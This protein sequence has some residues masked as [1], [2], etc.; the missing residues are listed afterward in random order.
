M[1]AKLYINL[2]N[3][4]YNI[5]KIREKLKENTGII[6]MVKANAYGAGMV[7]VAK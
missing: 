5:E 4:K 2:N 6:A 3:I 7:E 1:G